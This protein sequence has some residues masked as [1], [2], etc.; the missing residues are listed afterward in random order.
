[1]GRVCVACAVGTDDELESAV[2]V[3][4]ERRTCLDPITGVEVADL[5]DHAHL[6]VMDMAADDAVQTAAPSF[7]RHVKFEAIDEPCGT[8]HLPQRCGQRPIWVAK[9]APPPFEPT[10]S[11]ERQGVGMVA[12]LCEKLGV[13]DNAVE[14]VAMD[15]RHLLA[16]DC[17]ASCF[18]RQS[19][20]SYFCTESNPGA[21]HLVTI[22]CNVDDLGSRVGL[23]Q[24]CT[25]DGTVVFVPKQG[26]LQAP[27][28]DNVA[29]KVGGCRTS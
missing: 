20:A 2:M 19:D 1:M 28:V 24:G 7:L 4:D 26:P 22:A 27:P 6:R 5:P 14:D 11:N 18:F 3:L 16:I 13:E 15:H 9:A 17:H 25:H 23:A 8:F 10:V 29:D 21:E 12:K